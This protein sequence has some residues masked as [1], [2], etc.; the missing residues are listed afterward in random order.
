MQANLTTNYQFAVK[1]RS[2]AMLSALEERRHQFK[3]LSLWIMEWLVAFSTLFKLCEGLLPFPSG[4]TN[5]VSLHESFAFLNERENV[6]ERGF[7]L[8]ED[9]R[10]RFSGFTESF[11]FDIIVVIS[12]DDW[13]GRS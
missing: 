7:T 6:D 8:V 12:V 2:R 13:I 5:G 4:T 3:F 1:F 10:A 9:F 11:G